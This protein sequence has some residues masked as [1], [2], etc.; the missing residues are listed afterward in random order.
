MS[1]RT[2][3]G[4]QPRASGQAAR[5]H[6]TLTFDRQVTEEELRQMQA[7]HNAISAV[8]A[9]AAAGGHHHDHDARLE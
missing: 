4:A 7:Q 2:T 5:T 9:A 1:E 3:S 6:V 8:M